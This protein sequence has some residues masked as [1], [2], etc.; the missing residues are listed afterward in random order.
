[1]NKP[2]ATVVATG[3]AALILSS[4]AA[5]QEAGD[6]YVRVG[7]SRTKLVD[8][9]EIRVGGTLDP[10]AGYSTRPTYHGTLTAGYFLVDR[11]AVE[12]SISTPATTNNIPTGSIAG[13]PNLGDDEFVMATLGASVHPIKGPISPYVGG[14]I[15]AAFTTQQRDGLAVGLNV[16]NAH[17]PYVQ[18]GVD[19]AL[20][21]RFGLFFD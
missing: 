4:P 13:T 12:A 8:K 17:G 18:A 6:A 9:G 14:G 5:A 11:I 20:S 15:I 21:Q 16:P 3:L 2:I 1:M 10:N 7:A 19:F